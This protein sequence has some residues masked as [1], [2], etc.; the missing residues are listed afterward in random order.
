MSLLSGVCIRSS[1]QCFR[2]VSV[3][4]STLLQCARY[5][6]VHY[7][8]AHSGQE[9]EYPFDDRIAEYQRVSLASF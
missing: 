3:K 7:C 1:V 6:T 4:C 9:A 2:I 8:E 5:C